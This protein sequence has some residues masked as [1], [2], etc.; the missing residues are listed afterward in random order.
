MHDKSFQMKKMMMMMMMMSTLP[1]TCLPAGAT[2]LSTDDG[3]VS[4]TTGRVA[5]LPSEA[6]R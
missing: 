4:S 3:S 1:R 5:G 2:V 6:S